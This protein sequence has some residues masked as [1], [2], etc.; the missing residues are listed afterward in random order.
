M[1]LVPVPTRTVPKKT[2]E[3]SSPLLSAALDEDPEARTSFAGHEFLSCKVLLAV[4]APALFDEI[5]T[6][7]VD[8]LR[9]GVEK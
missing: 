1:R 9:P 8:H 5:D 3:W 6:V 7:E 2:G 4:I